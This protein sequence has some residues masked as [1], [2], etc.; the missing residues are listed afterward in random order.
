MLD[1]ADG[2]F[3]VTSQEPYAVL[4][5]VGD[6]EREVLMLGGWSPGGQQAPRT[7]TAKLVGFLENTGWSGL[8]GDL[9]LTDES[10]APFT[11]D[12]RTLG[13]ET[14]VAAEDQE[15]SYTRWI[16]A[17]V[18]LLLL[19][20][21]FQVVIAVRRDRKVAHSDDARRGP[22][23]RR[24]SRTSSSSPRAEPAA[25]PAGHDC[26]GQADARQEGTGHEPVKKTP[27]KKAPAKKTPVK[28]TPAKKAP[29]KKTP[30][31]AP[32]KKTSTKAPAKKAPP[33]ATTPAK[34]TPAPPR[35]T[36]RPRSQ[37]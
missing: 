23:I 36:K 2:S 10:A 4:E 29:V 28:K 35:V 20:L 21:A 1:Q 9:L 31:R 32:A 37:K 3:Q 13:Q 15:R 19:L 16:F 11:V 26:P 33:Q 14:R 8:A 17:G 27:A 12:S 7:L 34:A 24:T 25:R 6:G 30:A 5:A 18:A 22:A